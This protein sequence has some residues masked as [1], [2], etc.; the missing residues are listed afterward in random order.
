MK[1]PEDYDSHVG[2]IISQLYHLTDDELREVRQALN[3]LIANSDEYYER[4][5]IEQEIKD[6]GYACRVTSY[7]CMPKHIEKLIVQYNVDLC[8]EDKEKFSD[9][10]VSGDGAYQEP[11]VERLHFEYKVRNDDNWYKPAND[12]SWT[13]PPMDDEPATTIG[14][15]PVYIYYTVGLLPFEG[16]EFDSIN[17]DGRVEHW[18]IQDDKMIRDGHC[19]G[20]V[21]NWS[22]YKL[23]VLPTN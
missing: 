9:A 7:Y 3:E 1:A 8:A 16:S 20:C 11:W 6:K 19:V 12:K 22:A 4:K 10:K 17:E 23:L 5:K 15:M 18:E 2:E 14:T 13:I 21:G